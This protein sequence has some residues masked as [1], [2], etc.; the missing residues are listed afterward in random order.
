MGTQTGGDCA[1]FDLSGE[2]NPAK[3]AVRF[4]AVQDQGFLGSYALTVRKGNIVDPPFTIMATTGPSGETSGKLG[5]T[6]THGSA[7]SC[8]DLFG[9]KL[10][11]EPEADATDHVTAY[12]VPTSGNWLAPDQPFCTFSVNISATMRRT[13]GYNSAEDGFGPVQYLL[14]IQQ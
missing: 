4:K 14:G 11:E 8:G 9:T 12:I 13:N 2:P 10:I 7:V 3:L 6:Y 5:D 1:L